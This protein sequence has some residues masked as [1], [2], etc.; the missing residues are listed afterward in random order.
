VRL[1][2]VRHG[3]TVYNIE[4]RFTGQSDIPLSPLGERQELLVGEYLATEQPDVLV[5]SDLQR[6]RATAQAIARHHGLPVLEDR[7]LREISL[8]SWEGL[9]VYEV[10]M[11]D[12][13]G[14]VHWRSDP[15]HNGAGGGE[16]LTQF[17]A[18]IVRALERWYADYPEGTVVWVAHGGL[19]GVL[20][21]H[22]LAI[23]IKRRRQFHHDNASIS[24]FLYTAHSVSVVRLNETAFLR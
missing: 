4:H 18:R 12:E 17:H 16:T 23:D 15:L 5:S 20:V 6:A 14:L 1:I 24:E 7:N 21:C 8:G 11:S 3:E 10:M 13:D 9:T 2:V 19:M 22:M